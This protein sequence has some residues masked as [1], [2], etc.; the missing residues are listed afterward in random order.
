MFVHQTSKTG[1]YSCSTLLRCPPD[2]EKCRTCVSDFL[3]VNLAQKIGE[4][5]RERSSVAWIACVMLVLFDM[6]RIRR[7]Y[8]FGRVL[9]GRRWYRTGSMHDVVG[10]ADAESDE[11]HVRCKRPNMCETLWE[12]I[13]CLRMIPSGRRGLRLHVANL[14]TLVD[15]KGLLCPIRKPFL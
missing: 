9:H 14:R 4:S 1:C 3:N 10:G 13:L 8:C 5:M 12:R 15:V 6:A 7:W 2:E 11:E